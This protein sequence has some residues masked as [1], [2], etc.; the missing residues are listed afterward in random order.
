M[1][2]SSTSRPYGARAVS[3]ALLALSLL[4]AWPARAQEP[5]TAEDASTISPEREQMLLREAFRYLRLSR[6]Q[7]SQLLWFARQTDRRRVTVGQEEARALR[8]AE[9]LAARDP[10][11]AE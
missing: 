3:L 1:P 4:A 2:G 6:S 7:V 9:P 11:G 5:R 8:T 10:V